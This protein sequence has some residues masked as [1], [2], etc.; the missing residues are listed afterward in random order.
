MTTATKAWVPAP[1]PMSFEEIA[2]RKVRD[3]LKA[4][5]QIVEKHAAG[6]LVSGDEM[7]AAAQSLDHLGLPGY[8]FAR[9]VEALHRHK[10]TTKKHDAAVVAEPEHTARAAELAVEIDAVRAKYQK[11]REEHR[12]ASSHSSQPALFRQ[13]L[14]QLQLDHPHVLADLDIATQLRIEELDRRRRI[15]GGE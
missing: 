8:T 5:R 10:A 7:E 13:T 12:L 1:P 2:H 4:Y 15:G 14:E 11:L 3:H 9:D 6:E